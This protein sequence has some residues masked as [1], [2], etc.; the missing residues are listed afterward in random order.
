ME[1]FKPPRKRWGP[2]ALTRD[3]KL[4]RKS[5]KQSYELFASLITANKDVRKRLKRLRLTDRILNIIELPFRTVFWNIRQ[6]RNAIEI[7]IDL[8]EGGDK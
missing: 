1:N 6:R 8:I 7:Q 5:K 4:P 2:L 3:P